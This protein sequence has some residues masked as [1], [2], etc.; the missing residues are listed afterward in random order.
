MFSSPAH[1]HPDRTS[2]HVTTRHKSLQADHGS[3]KQHTTGNSDIQPKTTGN[4][5]ICSTDFLNVNNQSQRIRETH[6]SRLQK[7]RRTR[8][9]RQYRRPSIA[10]EAHVG[11]GGKR[12]SGPW[13]NFGATSVPPLSTLVAIH[14][15]HGPT[16]APP[17]YVQEAGGLLRLFSLCRIRA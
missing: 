12:H 10:E 3:R 14:A 2:F 5:N 6:P 16:S 4:P 9:S 15:L 11:T 13:R 7:C 17:P 8:R 1:H